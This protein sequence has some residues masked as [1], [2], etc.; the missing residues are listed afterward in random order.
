[1]YTSFYNG[2]VTKFNLKTFKKENQIYKFTDT[3]IDFNV[4]HCK[5]EGI[6]IEAVTCGGCIEKLQIATNKNISFC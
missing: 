5:K 2:A 1:M 6:S 4:T 3:I